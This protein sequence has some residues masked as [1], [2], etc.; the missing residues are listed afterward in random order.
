MMGLP[1]PY[2]ETPDVTIYHADCRDILPLL[3]SASVDLIVTDPPYGVRW[4]S[5]YRTEAFDMMQGDDGP[6]SAIEGLRLALKI[7]REGRHLY[8]FGR[9]DLGDLPISSPVELIWDK[10]NMGGGDLTLPWGQAHEYI[11]F[12]V[13]LPSTQN[14]IDGGGRLAARLRKGSVL[15]HPRLNATAVKTHPTE[16]PVMLLRELIESSSCIGETVLD[17]FMGSGST[18]VAAAME[19]RKAIGIEIEERY[20]E[21]A[22]KRMAQGVL[23]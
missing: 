18:L 1:A 7:L 19:G 3:P 12:A 20:C 8:T 13:Y 6:D 10:G 9:Y 16:K 21:I 5:N 22:A 2:F 15:R 17:P 4:Q 14:R 11:Q 23:L